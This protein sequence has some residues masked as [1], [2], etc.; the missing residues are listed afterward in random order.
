MVKLGSVSTIVKAK[1]DK[2]EL[3]HDE[4]RFF[5]MENISLMLKHKF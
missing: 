3:F 2:T 1:I 4:V 5:S